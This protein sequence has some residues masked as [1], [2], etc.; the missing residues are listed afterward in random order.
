MVAETQ[1]IKPYHATTYTKGLKVMSKNIDQVYQRTRELKLHIEGCCESMNR[2]I[3]AARRSGMRV[4]VVAVMGDDGGSYVS[5]Y[6]TGAVS[7]ATEATSQEA[8]RG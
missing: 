1:E 5:T 2:A 7:N 3:A 4:A 8:C 6:V